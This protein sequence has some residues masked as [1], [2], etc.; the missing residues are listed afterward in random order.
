MQARGRDLTDLTRV[1]PP[2]SNPHYFSA[3]P[4]HRVYNDRC[5]SE[6]LSLNEY[7]FRSMLLKMRLH[8]LLW[9][10]SVRFLG[11]FFLGWVVHKLKM[12]RDEV[13][14]LGMRSEI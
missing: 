9:G 3:L 5:I 12:D 1:L 2:W 4:L 6:R 7:C 14:K 13:L 10:K 11:N 8:R